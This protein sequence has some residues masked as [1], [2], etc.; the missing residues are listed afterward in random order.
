[1]MHSRARVRLTVY[2]QEPAVNWIR[3]RRAGFGETASVTTATVG[4]TG[5]VTGHSAQWWIGAHGGRSMSPRE[6]QDRPHFLAHNEV[7][8]RFPER[9]SASVALPRPQDSADVA[10]GPQRLVPLLHVVG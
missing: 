10:V 5:N 6:R 7:Q 8:A 2:D 4:R 3:S 1:M 9:P